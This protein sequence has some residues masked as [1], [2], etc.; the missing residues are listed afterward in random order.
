MA[1][2]LS[3]TI[4]PSSHAHQ[5]QW[6]GSPSGH[7]YALASHARADCTPNAK[8]Y[9]FSSGHPG[10]V[11]CLAGDDS[12]HWVSN[13]INAAAYHS[14]GSRRQMWSPNGTTWSPIVKANPGEWKPG[15]RSGFAEIQAQWR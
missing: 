3:A 4:S 12:V 7:W 14:L 5:P 9:G 2:P 6:M 13:K 1:A 10:G 8:N 11:H 15:T